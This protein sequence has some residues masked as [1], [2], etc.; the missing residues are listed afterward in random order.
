MSSVTTQA[1]VRPHDHSQDLL[2][3]RRE[4]LE[5]RG[6]LASARTSGQELSAL[7][8]PNSWSV[9]SIAPALTSPRFCREQVEVQPIGI[10]R[11]E[12]MT[13]GRSHHARAWFSAMT[14]TPRQA[15][16]SLSSR[17]WRGRAPR[18]RSQC[19]GWRSGG[20]PQAGGAGELGR[21][22][23]PLTMVSGA[24][25]RSTPSSPRSRTPRRGRRRRR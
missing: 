7:R 24:A 10:V 17:L 13:A 6:K 15:A 23:A 2:L 25:D 1:T 19:R 14:T 12:R 4:P 11:L 5:L 16:F 18:G 3:C 9:L 20:R 21:G 8:S 22:P